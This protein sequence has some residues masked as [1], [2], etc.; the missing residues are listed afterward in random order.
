MTGIDKLIFAPRYWFKLPLL[1]VLLACSTPQAQD[2]E[3][4]LQRRAA[5]DHARGEFPDPPDEDRIRE[6]EHQVT[7]FCTG[8]DSELA[9]LKNR[10]RLDAAVSKLLAAFDSQIEKVVK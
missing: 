6:V 3:M 5:C 2:L 7:K 10:Y 4:F 8:T 9:A 1:G